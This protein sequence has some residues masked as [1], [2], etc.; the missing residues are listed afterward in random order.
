MALTGGREISRTSGPG[1]VEP[2]H[3]I[4]GRTIWRGSDF[5]GSGDWRH[6]LSAAELTELR[7]AI[8]EAGSVQPDMVDLK[9]H[10]FPLPS[11]GPVLKRL[12]DEI[13]NGRGFV[14]IRGLPVAEMSRREAAL[15]FWGIGLHLGRPVSQNMAGHMLG[16][17]KDT[18]GDFHDVNSRGG[19]Q[20]RARLP[21]H[22]DLGADIVGLLCLQ[23][24][25]AG[26]L[27]SLVSAHAIHNAMLARNPDLVETLAAAIYRDR[28]GEIPE[29]KA[30]Y[31]QAPVFCYHEG[32][33]TTTFVRR[34]I[35]S[36]P[37]HEGV[38]PLTAQLV[39]A[40]ELFETLAND[41]HLRLDMALAAGD[42]QFVNNLTTL[43]S[44]TAF[45]DHPDAGR[46]RHLLRLWLAADNAWPLPSEH[47][48]RFGTAGNNTRPDGMI[49]TGVKPNVPLDAE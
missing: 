41:P 34:F 22:T 11:L 49:G 35:D 47:Y 18:G 24:A 40:L 13:V 25:K 27:S 17:V 44:R 48:E 9:R 31:Y 38:P 14:L 45:E 36:A 39:E 3:P 30:P 1:T 33:M 2:L 26:G 16:H 20:S 15:A 28:R 10:D 46:K 32:Y 4:V 7:V 12:K 8:A 23:T 6:T 5:Q 29:G 42:M 19:Y 21:Y 43:H 37:R